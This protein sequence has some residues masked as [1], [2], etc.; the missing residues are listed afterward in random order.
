MKHYEILTGRIGQVRDLVELGNGNCVVNFSVAET[1]R[2]KDKSG[3]WVDGETIWTDVSIFGDEARNLVRSVKPGTFVTVI[4]TRQARSYTPK[5]S[6]EKRV[7]QQVTAEQV[8]VAITKFH[9]IESIG[10]VNYAK[11]GRGGGQAAP[12][13]GG[14]GYNQAQ[15]APQG[16]GFQGGGQDS[17]P[18]ADNT[19]FDDPFADSGDDPFGLG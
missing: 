1:P 10:N 8:S 3:Q 16:G 13:Q 12:S 9:Y 4:G 11:T 6:N 14:G 19:S 18:F 17:D 7:I 5:D 2:Y 15:Q